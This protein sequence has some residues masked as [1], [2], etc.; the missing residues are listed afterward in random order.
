MKLYTSSRQLRDCSATA[1]ASIPAMLLAAGLASTMAQSAQAAGFKIANIHFETNASACDMGIRIAFDT[2]GLTEGRVQDPKGVT[3]YKFEAVG[4]MK[5]T[6][7]QTEGSVEGIKRQIKEIVAALG[8]GPSDEGVSTLN[9]F[10]SSWPPGTYTFHSEIGGPNGT[11]LDGRDELTYK[12][13]AGPKILAPSNGAVVPDASALIRWR[14]VTTAILPRLGP[15]NITGYH[16]I[17]YETGGEGLPEFD[18]D[19]PASETNVRVPVQF[20]KPSTTYQFEVLSTEE[21]G[22]QTI[23]EGFFCTTGVTTCAMPALPSR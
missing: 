15:V 9:A 1:F 7:G 19:L 4:G 23:T 14:P 2:E 17:V 10:R 5:N 20:L 6:G 21:S 18:I 16:V 11:K 12:I 3:V 22:N 13:P 8:C